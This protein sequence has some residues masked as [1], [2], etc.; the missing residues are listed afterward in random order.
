MWGFCEESQF[1]R[2]DKTLATVVLKGW[3]EST[4]LHV[5]E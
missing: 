3:Q 5:S 4:T 1:H 2:L